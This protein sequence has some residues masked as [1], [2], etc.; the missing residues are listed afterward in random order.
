MLQE[1]KRLLKTFV[2][3]AHVLDYRLFLFV[4]ILLTILAPLS[5]IFYFPKRSIF[6]AKWAFLSFSL[7]VV[8]LLL[9]L[10][11]E[12]YPKLDKTILRFIKNVSVAVKRKISSWYL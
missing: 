7:S 5:E 4:G 1:I 10:L 11:T 12:T 2:L 3:K 6:F 8:V 9:V